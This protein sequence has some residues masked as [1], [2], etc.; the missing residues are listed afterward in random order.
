M[1]ENVQFTRFSVDTHLPLI[2]S[3]TELLHRAYAPLAEMGM[4]YLASHQLPEKTLERLQEGESYLAF[5]KND[6][7]G[8]V[9]LYSEKETSSCEYY[10]KAGIFSF[11]QFAIQPGHQGRGFG[12]SMMDMLE[13]RAKQLGAR[14]LA[15]DTSEHADNLIRM[16][17]KRGYARVS[18]TKWDVTNYRSVIMSK[19]L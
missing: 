15:L 14:E 5:L 3:L 7:I 2:N 11:G 8:T 10:R 18:Y 9:T 19:K 12:S 1:S 17:E 6:L 4:K 13:L 16:Y